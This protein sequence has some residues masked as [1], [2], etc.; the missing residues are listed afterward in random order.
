M[1]FNCLQYI[2]SSDC[3]AKS[4][5]KTVISLFPGL[6]R[7]NM[8]LCRT[9]SYWSHCFSHF[10][11]FYPHTSKYCNSLTNRM[12]TPKVDAN[13]NFVLFLRLQELRQKN[14]ER[15]WTGILDAN[16]SRTLL[17]GWEHKKSQFIFSFHHARLPSLFILRRIP[18]TKLKQA[19]DNDV[20]STVL[21]MWSSTSFLLS[22]NYSYTLYN[23]VS[24]DLIIR[25][26]ML[27]NT[28]LIFKSFPCFLQTGLIS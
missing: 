13:L 28:R 16:C 24:A 7:I 1:T 17:T 21:S 23:V 12:V 9:G 25:L 14:N 27:L 26:L 3:I 4:K 8:Y 15:G 11:K 20:T 6:S 2:K 18:N 5:S 10:E 22:V 19:I